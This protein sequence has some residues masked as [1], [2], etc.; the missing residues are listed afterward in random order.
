MQPGYVGRAAEKSQH[1]RSLK[2]GVFPPH[3]PPGV[4]H[5]VV[6]PDAD[7]DKPRQPDQ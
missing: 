2:H 4:P 7:E 6:M 5:M 1:F 3:I